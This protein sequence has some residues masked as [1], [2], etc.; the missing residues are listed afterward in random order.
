MDDRWGDNELL[1]EIVEIE[2]D[3][4]AALARPDVTGHTISHECGADCPTCFAP[5]IERASD[6][7]IVVALRERTESSGRLL[8]AERSGG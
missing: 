5:A 2:A 8:A 1:D 4:I 7:A 3:A 6:R